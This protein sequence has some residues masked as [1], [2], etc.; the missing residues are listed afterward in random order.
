MKTL[1]CL[2]IDG[3]CDTPIEG[4]TPEQMLNN[5]LRHLAEAVR[6]YPEHQEVLDKIRLMSEHE[7]AQWKAEFMEKWNSAPDTENH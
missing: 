2:E 3:I 4:Q 1:T 7:Q 5:R 6:I